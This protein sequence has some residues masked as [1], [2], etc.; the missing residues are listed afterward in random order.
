MAKIAEGESIQEA[1][2]G[3]VVGSGSWSEGPL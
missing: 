2:T 3:R 1:E